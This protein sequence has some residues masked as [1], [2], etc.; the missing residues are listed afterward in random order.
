[1]FRLTGALGSLELLLGKQII[2]IEGG[3]FLSQI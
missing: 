3:A 2:M 1:M